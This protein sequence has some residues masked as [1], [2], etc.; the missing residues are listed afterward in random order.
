MEAYQTLYCS[1][2]AF[3][4]RKALQVCGNYTNKSNNYQSA[5]GSFLQF[6]YVL[7]LAFQLHWVVIFVN[8]LLLTV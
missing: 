8:T 1:S 7:L 6:Y 4:M 3:G 5:Y 2:I